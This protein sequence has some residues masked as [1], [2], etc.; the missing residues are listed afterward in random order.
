MEILKKA[1]DG[2]LVHKAFHTNLEPERELD[3][4]CNCCKCCCG[5]F[6][7]HYG[8][9]APLMDITSHIAKVD[10]DMCIG[11]ET[12]FQECNAEAIEMID[13]KAIID[14]ERCIGCGVCAHLCPEHAMKLE[15]I[16]L[17]KVFSSPR[18]SINEIKN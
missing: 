7:I 5:T 16:D 10:D 8:G 17:R 1:E 9:G 15:R 4:I 11:C 18:E 13:N 14:E 6:E 12:C 3:G 2:G